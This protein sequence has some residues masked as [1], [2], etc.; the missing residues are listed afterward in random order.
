[1]EKSSTRPASWILLIFM[2]I[3]CVIPICVQYKI[4]TGETFYTAKLLELSIYWTQPLFYWALGGALAALHSAIGL[5]HLPDFGKKKCVGLF[6]GMILLSL[7]LLSLRYALYF[8]F[9]LLTNDLLQ[10]YGMVH[11]LLLTFSGDCT[12]L[13]GLS[14]I[15]SFSR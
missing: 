8:V 5:L 14:L 13:T 11:A 3:L 10:K 12:L 1:M 2:L 4:V 9:S 7:I 15:D 6:L